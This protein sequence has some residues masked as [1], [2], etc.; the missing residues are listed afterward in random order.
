MMN[1]RQYWL[2]YQER[3]AMG[4]RESLRSLRDR[5]FVELLDTVIR[6]G[7]DVTHNGED[8][9]TLNIQA[10]KPALIKAS[11]VDSGTGFP[12]EL[13]SPNTYGDTSLWRYWSPDNV[14]NVAT[15]GHIFVMDQT[16]IDLKIGRHERTRQLTF[17]PVYRDVADLRFKIESDGGRWIVVKVFPR[18]LSIVG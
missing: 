2:V 11:S 5:N 13:I 16:S 18:Q 14:E 7:A 3:E 12:T 6:H 15:R 10:A 1:L 8:P 4:Y 17:R 9:V